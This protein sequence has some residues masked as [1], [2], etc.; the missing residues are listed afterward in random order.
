MVALY[1]YDRTM[2]ERA[3]KAI[4]KRGETRKA[5]QRMANNELDPRTIAQ[6]L[7]ISVSAVYYHLRQLKNELDEGA[8]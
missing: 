2:T 7:G 6:A 4:G 5:V 1:Q 3:P 8:A